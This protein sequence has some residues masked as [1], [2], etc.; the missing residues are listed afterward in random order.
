MKKNLSNVG[1]RYLGN[2]IFAMIESPIIDL[3][4]FERDKPHEA[5]LFDSIFA[6]DERT[7]LPQGDLAVFMSENTSP[8]VKQ[9]IQ[10]NL[11]QQNNLELP[12]NGKDL[13]DDIISALTRGSGESVSSYRD[14]VMD[15][16]KQS[17]RE[18]H[19]VEAK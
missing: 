13:D 16:L 9:F 19:D 2:R 1:K 12:E 18:S 3:P 8:E 7:K 10:Q 4:I 6:I 15:W 14:R 17:M 5:S 11:L